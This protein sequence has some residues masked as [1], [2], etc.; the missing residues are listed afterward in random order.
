[1]L[2]EPRQACRTW[3]KTRIVEPLPL[4]ELGRPNSGT[5]EH[6]SKKDRIILKNIVDWV[7]LN[8]LVFSAVSF[9]FFFTNFA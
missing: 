4:L 1:M 3:Q 8:V 2:T 7:C 6:Y 5:N 9:N